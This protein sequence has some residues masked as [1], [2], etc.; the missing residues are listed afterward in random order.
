MKITAVHGY[1]ANC[2]E[3]TKFL[4]SALGKVDES[5]RTTTDEMLQPS[6][7]MTATTNL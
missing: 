2:L 3:A 7:D 6:V 1:G 4:E 5:T